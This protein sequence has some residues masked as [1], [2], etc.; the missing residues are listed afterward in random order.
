MAASLS[1]TASRP[2]AHL[3]LQDRVKHDVPPF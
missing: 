3:A 1:S 2:R